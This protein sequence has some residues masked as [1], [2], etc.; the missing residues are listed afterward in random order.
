MELC[1]REQQRGKAQKHKNMESAPIN[2]A[3]G[4]I[5]P[6][7]YASEK[8]AEYTVA[9][10]FGNVSLVG[11]SLP[12]SQAAPMQSLKILHALSVGDDI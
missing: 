5:S 9:N 12:Y 6:V 8:S 1:E 4:F 2:Q 10:N 7:L 3:H 11:K